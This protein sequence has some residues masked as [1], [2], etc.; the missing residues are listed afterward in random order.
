MKLLKTLTCEFL[1][2]AFLLATVVGSGILGNN[3][4]SGNVAV[5][6]L[7]ISLAT[8]CV[9]SALIVTFGGISAHFNPIVTLTALFEKTISIRDAVLYFVAQICGASLGVIA[10]NV[11][12]DLPA[13]VMSQHA[14]TGTGQWL[15]E[16]IATFGLICVIQGCAR[17]RPTAIPFTVAAYVCG[18]IWFTSSTCFANPAVTISRALTDTIT[19]IRLA[20][21]GSFILAQCAGG[22]SAWL[23]CAW[24]FKPEAQPAADT[25]R[26]LL[27]A[28]KNEIE[29]RKLSSN[30]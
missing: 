28:L 6:V 27:D 5:T 26:E 10:A 23:I 11:M 13:V 15:G 21:V 30:S 1:G 8:G 25:D 4:D 2:T 3:I 7:A 29:R 20:D 9:L 17:F 12:F 19:G 22:V 18:A 14:R 24:L 16:F